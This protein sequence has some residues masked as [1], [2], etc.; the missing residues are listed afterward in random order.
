MLRTMIIAAGMCAAATTSASPAFEVGVASGARAM[1][2]T[3]VD[4][5]TED[6]S[7]ESLALTAAY[8]VVDLPALGLRVRA[9][10]AYLHERVGGTT[11]QQIDSDLVTHGVRAGA[12]V[13]RDLRSWLTLHAGVW[14]GYKRGTLALSDRAF[15]SARATEDTA[16]AA[17]VAATAGVDLAI[18]R[19]R[20]WRLVARTE[21]EY[22]RA[23]A[24]HFVAR[25]AAGDDGALTIPTRSASLGDLDTSGPA[26]HVGIAV[27]F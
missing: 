18:V 11:Y 14:A 16:R 9:E 23:S 10:V 4:T 2:S 17:T 3:S 25:P 22:E 20:S 12:R 1:R 19:R 8:R 24:M 13:E 7:H 21:F 26:I 6:D 5:L 27:Q 15:G